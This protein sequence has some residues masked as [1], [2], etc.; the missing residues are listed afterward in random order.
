MTLI[1]GSPSPDQAGATLKVN[2]AAL[3]QNWRTL[4]KRAGAAECSAVVKAD[5]YG[6]GLEPAARTLAKAG[7]RS[8]FVAHVFEAVAL[9]GFAP[10][11]TI[12]VLNGLVPGTVPL[13]VAHRLTPVL[14]SLPEL[15]E[16]AESGAG[17]G[18]AI[19]LDTGLNRLGLEAYELAEAA[20]LLAAL[21]ID[22][23]LSHFASSEDAKDPTNAAQIAAFNALRAQVPK[24][25][26]SL[27]NSSGIYLGK[28]ALFDLVRP[29]YALYGGNPTPGVKNPMRSVVALH[30]RV[31]Q[32]R[33]VK[34]GERAGYNG[35]WTA[36]SP[37]ILATLSLGY[38][39]G[40]LRAA[41]G[42]AAHQGGE[43]IVNGVRCPFVGRVSMD[44]TILD[45][46]DAGAVARGDGVEIL[47]PHISVDD[48][49]ARADTIGY[50]IL[51]GLGRRYARVY[52][53]G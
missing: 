37:R 38:A 14:G 19:M 20:P 24:A 39:D 49:G 32:T 36:P 52:T 30:A 34:M 46:T 9:R 44:L 5:A 45:V 25:R 41:R 26:A 50:E 48:L 12:Y 53:G 47:G 2:L 7:C 51:T 17:L 8:F 6:V 29:G 35:Q 4:A 22:L 16:W 23:V 33:R 10:D 15:R 40:L 31:V 42:T 11:A 1:S 27:A 13:Y 43:A 18:V 28:E 3:A 21:K